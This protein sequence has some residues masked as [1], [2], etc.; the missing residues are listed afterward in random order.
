MAGV[1]KET[2]K[3]LGRVRRIRGQVAALER[4]IEAGLPSEKLMQQI[5]SCRGALSGLMALVAESHIQTCLG[6][7][8]ARLKVSKPLLDLVHSYFR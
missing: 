1:T 5:A 7:S 4:A 8:P 6:D 2:A 3:M